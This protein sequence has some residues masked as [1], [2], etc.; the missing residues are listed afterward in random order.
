MIDDLD[1]AEFDEAYRAVRTVLTQEAHNDRVIAFA[2]LT[3]IFQDLTR[4]LPEERR[5]AVLQELEANLRAGWR[6][7]CETNEQAH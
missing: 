3:V 4:D 2:L 7:L 1:D 6:L 5:E